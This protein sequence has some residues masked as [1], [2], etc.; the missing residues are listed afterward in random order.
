MA[1]TAVVMATHNLELTRTAGFRVVELEQ[2]RV[3][4]DSA[5]AGAAG[6]AT[7]DGGPLPGPAA[8]GAR[9]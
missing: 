5:A 8:W 4:Y 7:L 3:V 9:S 2:G 6:L 1:G